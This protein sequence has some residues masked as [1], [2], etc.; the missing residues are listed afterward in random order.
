M[1]SSR[2]GVSGE[3]PIPATSGAVHRLDLQERANF[4]ASPLRAPMHG[5]FYLEDDLL[6]GQQQGLD[7]LRERTA[8]VREAMVRMI[9]RDSARRLARLGGSEPDLESGGQSAPPSAA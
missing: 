5:A 6:D 2:T 4:A 7:G 1:T 9:E 3:P 8:R